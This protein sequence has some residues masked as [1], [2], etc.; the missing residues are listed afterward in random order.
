MMAGSD[1]SLVVEEI[2]L[3][4]ST[5]TSSIS[6]SDRTVHRHSIIKDSAQ[7]D[8]LQNDELVNR[9]VRPVDVEIRN[10]TVGYRSGDMQTCW[11]DLRTRFR[12]LLRKVTKV[13]DDLEH[14]TPRLSGTKCILDHVS[15]NMAPGTLTAI[16]GG[17]G[18]GKTTLLNTVAQRV[19]TSMV[20]VTGEVKYSGA[21]HKAVRMAYLMQ[22]DLLRPELTVRETLQ[23]AADLR[24]PSLSTSTQRK[25]VVESVISELG[26]REC[27]DTRIGSSIHKGCSGGE[28]RRVSIAVQMLSNPSVLFCDEPTTGQTLGM[29][30][31]S[32]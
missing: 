24:L 31:S 19:A 5:S 8:T 17:S 29:K 12:R 28:K 25:A 27:A 4:S 13:Q 30:I 2:E 10:L 22:Q 6:D 1:K 9:C 15:A 3:A 23:D 32:V 14:G 16:L 21:S 26:L 20:E 11:Q 18:S 7:F